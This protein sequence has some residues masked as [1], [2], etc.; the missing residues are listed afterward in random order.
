[1]PA[2][3]NALIRYRIIDKCLR[4]K[5]HKY[6]NKDYIRQ[7]ISE[8]LYGIDEPHI[9]ES[10][11]V[12]DFNAM[13]TDKALGYMAPIKYSKKNGGYHYEDPEY[14]IDGL[15][16]SDQ[17]REAL[18][19]S[20]TLLRS[21]VGLP[22]LQNLTDAIE[23]INTRFSITSWADDD[24]NNYLEFEKTNLVTGREWIH[25]LYQAIRNRHP[26]KFIYNNTYKDEIR[27]HALEPYYLRETH[28]AWYLM[29][30]NANRDAFI[31]YHLEKIQSLDVDSTKTFRRKAMNP[32]EYFKHSLGI[33]GGNT[34]PKKIILEVTGHFS[35]AVQIQKIHHSQ[36]VIKTIDNGLIIE[37]TLHNNDEL[38]RKI[39]SMTG[40]VKVI[41]PA[42]LR[43]K[44]IEELKG[45]IEG[46]GV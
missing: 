21:F 22:I 4:S 16:L 13:K 2:N 25:S 19:E 14:S 43:K 15:T 5:Q 20:A 34:Q 3:K 45:A 8:E 32:N 42:S 41:K 38:F 39:I 24:L 28:N 26:I 37:L 46:Y 9:S 1:M 11:I 40:S 12:K 30:R 27:E 18:Q 23:K 6:P 29:G 36:K 33:Y 31:I 35:R 44:V 7:K 10:M 17:E